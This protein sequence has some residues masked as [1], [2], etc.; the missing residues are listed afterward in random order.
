MIEWGA[1]WVGIFPIA[2]AVYR[3]CGQTSPVE[4]AVDLDKTGLKLILKFF[5]KYGPEKHT[6][7]STQIGL[8]ENF[9][10]HKFK[11]T[12]IWMIY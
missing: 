7:N 12:A 2:G 3:R 8:G 5:V 4:L 10:W 11:M 6:K 9:L 1:S